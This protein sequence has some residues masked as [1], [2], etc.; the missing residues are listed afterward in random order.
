MLLQSRKVTEYLPWKKNLLNFAIT[1]EKM[2]SNSYLVQPQ[3]TIKMLCAEQFFS[4]H[5][6]YYDEKDTVRPEN[7]KQKLKCYYSLDQVLLNERKIKS[8]SV[9]I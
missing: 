2:F 6:M 7:E 4:H 3:Q 5:Q 9:S 8:S 1:F